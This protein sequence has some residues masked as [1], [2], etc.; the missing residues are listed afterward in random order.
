MLDIG[1]VKMTAKLN[2]LFARLVPHSSAVSKL[3][4]QK[5]SVCLGRYL[6]HITTVGHHRYGS[7][8]AS[9]NSRE[10]GWHLNAGIPYTNADTGCHQ[11]WTSVCIEELGKP[12]SRA[13]L[14]HISFTAQNRP[15]CFMDRC[16]LL[17]RTARNAAPVSNGFLRPDVLSL[18]RTT[19]TA[20]VRRSLLLDKR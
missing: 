5:S 19:S 11:G 10:H 18:K 12:V 13:V 14:T 9:G 4:D 20:A 8:L 17:E 6:L 3:P 7:F 2:K 16:P 1:K 15:H